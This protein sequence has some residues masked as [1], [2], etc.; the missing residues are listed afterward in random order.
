MPLILR[1]LGCDGTISCWRLP[2]VLPRRSGRRRL[3]PKMWLAFA[4][5]LLMAI[6][7][8]ISTTEALSRRNIDLLLMVRFAAGS[9]EVA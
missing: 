8:Q 1:G 7:T 3:P 2:L 6:S 5:S 9:F 4:A